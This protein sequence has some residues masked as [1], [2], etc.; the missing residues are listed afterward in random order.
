VNNG[1]ILQWR[2]MQRACHETNAF[3]CGH[4]AILLYKI[5]LYFPVGPIDISANV[6]IE[7]SCPVIPI[8]AP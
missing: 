1:W 2:G 8:R 3:T 6:L 5:A 7:N 4:L